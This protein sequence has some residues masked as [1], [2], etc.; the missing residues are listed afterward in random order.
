MANINSYT[1]RFDDD[2]DADCLSITAAEKFAETVAKEALNEYIKQTGNANANATQPS[3]KGIKMNTTGI[4]KAADDVLAETQT[5]VGLISGELLLENIETIADKLI[6]SRLNWWQKLT[7]TKT[8]RELA[9]TI[10]TYAIV[11]AIKTG[12]FGLTKY[13][14]NHVALDFV[15]LAANARLLKYIIKS[16]GV[17]FNVAKALLSTPT[18]TEG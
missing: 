3:S 14:V 11:H 18:I 2:H 16:T 13:K 15:T 5:N 9:V 10:A 7:I 1:D 8:N 6:L 4:T 12:G 17:D